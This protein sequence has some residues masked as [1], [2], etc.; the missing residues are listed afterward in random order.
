MSADN[1][2]ICPLCE[3]ER[4]EKKIKDIKNVEEGYGILTKEEY[5]EAIRCSENEEERTKTLR[6]DY[7]IS[8]DDDGLFS[9][10]YTCHC[11]E[12]RFT[13]SFSHKENLE[14]VST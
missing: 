10:S 1:W 6:E 9:V 14:V 7:E 13:Y 3:K 8:T 11:A 4:K 2:T 5:L 12:C